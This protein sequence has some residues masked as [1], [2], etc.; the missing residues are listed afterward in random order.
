M[1][2]HR[3]VPPP[4]KAPREPDS[5]ADVVLKVIVTAWVVLIIGPLVLAL[6]EG[7]RR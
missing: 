1:T 3:S 6:L 5:T 7:M 4:R 2:L